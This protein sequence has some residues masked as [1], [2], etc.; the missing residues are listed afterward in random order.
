MSYPGADPSANAGIMVEREP[1]EA[2]FNANSNPFSLKSL[3]Q[4]STVLES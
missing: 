1:R 3:K 4:A 2:H